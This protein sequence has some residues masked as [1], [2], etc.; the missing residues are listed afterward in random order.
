MDT[1]NR[2]A[3]DVGDLLG[4]VADPFGEAETEVTSSAT[5]VVIGRSRLPLVH[6][7]EALYHVARFDAVEEAA[8]NVD[9]FQGALGD[10]SAR[11]DDPP[12]V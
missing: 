12:I 1:E 7:G 8:E 10:A 11:A 5:G 3:A 2:C 9:R 4:V 6:E